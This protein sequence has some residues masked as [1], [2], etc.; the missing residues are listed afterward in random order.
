MASPEGDAAGP[1]ASAS[2]A[3]MAQHARSAAVAQLLEQLQATQ[4]TGVRRSPGDA[5]A[6]R[7]LE[8]A[9]A[10]LAE[11]QRFR[12]LVGRIE[13]AMRRARDMGA[14]SVGSR[15]STASTAA[16]AST[17]E[18]VVGEREADSSDEW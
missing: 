2:D 9:D 8:R 16:P 1:A 14:L 13:T 3:P 4:R 15:P 5:A 18:S 6:R 12:H 11:Q 7:I 10:E 17:S